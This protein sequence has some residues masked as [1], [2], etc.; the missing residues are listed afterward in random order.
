MARL[1][2]LTRRGHLKVL[3]VD[4]GT[5]ALRTV[6]VPKTPGQFY[7]VVLRYAGGWKPGPVESTIRI[8]TG[9]QTSLYAFVTATWSSRRTITT[10][11]S[12]SRRCCGCGLG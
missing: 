1:Q 4:T 10:G 2:V 7:D 6:V 8:R 3:G 9:T 11:L 5:P 12:Q